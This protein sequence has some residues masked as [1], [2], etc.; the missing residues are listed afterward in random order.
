[1]RSSFP[2]LK[3]SQPGRES[4]GIY[5]TKDAAN[6]ALAQHVGSSP[7]SLGSS[8]RAVHGWLVEQGLV[9][10]GG[11]S[12]RRVQDTCGHMVKS[13]L[14]H[15]EGGKLFVKNSDRSRKK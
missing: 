4:L 10:K 9:E 13:G 3:L 14:V 1:M 7:G 2:F 6:E 11:N 15:S 12:H 5:R 8:W